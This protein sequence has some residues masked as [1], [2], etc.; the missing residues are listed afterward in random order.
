MKD[1][2]VILTGGKNNAG[3]FLI[4]KKAKELFTQLRPDRSVIDYDGWLP[5]T[6]EQLK[7]I[8]ES[9]A[10]ILTGGPALRYEMYPGIY[11]LVEN[12]DDIKVPILMMGIGWKS[13]KGDWED[14]YHYPLSPKTIELLK[15]IDNSGYSSSVRDYHTL[16]V[17]MHGG[18]KNTL[19]TGCPALYSHKHLNQVFK[20]P[21][22]IKNVSF[23]LGVSFVDNQKIEDQMKLLILK[24]KEIFP[25]SNLTVVFHHS[26][27]KKMI[28]NI[29]KGKTF[30]LERH[31]HM[32]DWLEKNKIS[33][34]D[35]SGGVD[36]L[37]N[38][39]SA[40]DFHIGYRVHAHIFMNS[41]SKLTML[42]S[43]DGRGKALEKVIGGMVLDG[44]QLKGFSKSIFARIFRKVMGINTNAFLLQDELVSDVEMNVLYELKYNC[45]R[46]TASRTNI[47]HHFNV[48]KRFIKQ[49]P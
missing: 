14:S 41:I 32:V 35:I 47:D 34:I 7:T 30:F 43:E 29:Y 38:H 26:L 36:T 8:N 45:P 1:Q 28:T 13:L 12:L 9:R 37:V 44:Y 10:L 11:P 25:E 23:S 6:Q 39:Y 27:D 20:Y 31:Y 48:M 2:Y 49:L 5:L 3:D 18:F 15:K 17:L 16:N 4:K 40:C 21:K 24:T 42:I 46:V 33:Y 22:L 19:M